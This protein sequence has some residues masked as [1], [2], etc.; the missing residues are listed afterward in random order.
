MLKALAF[1]TVV[2]FHSL[3]FNPIPS[4]CH[5]DFTL[6][7]S[8]LFSQ[9][10]EVPL[11]SCSCLLRCLPLW[12][13]CCSEYFLGLQGCFL[14]YSLDSVYLL[15][16]FSPLLTSSKSAF[17]LYLASVYLSVC[18]S[19]SAH[20]HVIPCFSLASAPSFLLASFQARC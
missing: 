13:F 1:Y 19:S 9:S 20:F 3:Y 18:L 15:A 12:C 2:L 6:L 5:I 10:P 11:Q 14:L 8:Q 4:S 16:C 7:S 17:L